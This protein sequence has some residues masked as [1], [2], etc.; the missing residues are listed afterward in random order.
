ML[1]YVLLCVHDRSLA[2]WYDYKLYFCR[3]ENA[4][5][6]HNHDSAPPD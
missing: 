5:P 1:A 3:E 6:Q 2:K 4:G